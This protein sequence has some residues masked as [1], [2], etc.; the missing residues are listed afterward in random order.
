MLSLRCNP[1][2]Q[3]RRLNAT[4]RVWVDVRCQAKEGGFCPVGCFQLGWVVWLVGCG[5]ASLAASVAVAA[6]AGVA[7]AAAAAFVYLSVWLREHVCV[8]DDDVAAVVLYAP[9]YT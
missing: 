7:A 5:C 9:G 3:G 8:C 6:A 2:A 1:L 4:S